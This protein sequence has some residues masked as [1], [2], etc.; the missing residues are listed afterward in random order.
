MRRQPLLAYACTSCEQCNITNCEATK[1]TKS[2]LHTSVFNPTVS[3]AFSSMSVS[4]PSVS[5]FYRHCL[6]LFLCS[7]TET[8]CLLATW[9]SNLIQAQHKVVFS[10][11]LTTGNPIYL[12]FNNVKPKT[13]IY[14]QRHL[15]QIPDLSDWKTQTKC[16]I[17]NLR[18]FSFFCTGHTRLR[19]GKLLFLDRH[20]D[21]FET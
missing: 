19:A 6:P 5:S 2:L 15:G 8:I 10:L 1:Q 21:A 3:L 16:K 18:L 20:V 13:A 7:A 11:M 9:F 12:D 14:P 4:A 17:F